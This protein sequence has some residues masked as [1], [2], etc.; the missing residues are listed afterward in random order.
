MAE[1]VGINT[2]VYRNVD[3]HYTFFEDAGIITTPYSADPVAKAVV[4]PTQTGP[5]TGVYDPEWAAMLS[6]ER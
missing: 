5:M 4:L 2:G 1:E 6:M 3:P